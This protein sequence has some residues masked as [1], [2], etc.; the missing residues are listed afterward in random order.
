V[1]LSEAIRMGAMLRPQMRGK[2]LDE[3]GSCALG[4]A[5]EANGAKNF[6]DLRTLYPWIFEISDY[7]IPGMGGFKAT[8]VARVI[9]CLNDICHWTREQ[10]ADWVEKNEL[11]Q[12]E[13][14]ALYPAAEEP[15]LVAR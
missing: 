12:E 8:S 1:R 11:H 15:E 13:G 10:I 7:E 6:S 4:A 3:Q 9:M 14:M 2:M 5:A